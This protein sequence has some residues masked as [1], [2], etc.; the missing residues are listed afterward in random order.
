MWTGQQENGQSIN[1]QA[2]PDHTSEQVSPEPRGRLEQLARQLA[3]NSSVDKNP[4]Q[5]SILFRHLQSWEKT[6]HK[7]YEYF[8]AG[9]SKDLAFSRAAEW[10]LDNF[11]VVEQMLHQIK[12]DLPES[13]YSQLPKLDKTA[14]RGFPRIFELA[15]EWVGYSQGQLELTQ[16]VVFVQDYQQIAPLMIGE[17]W[18]LPT[19]LRIGVLERLTA[20][21]A[22]ITGIT[23]PESLN[24]LPSLPAPPA[25]ANE[26]IVVNCFLSLRLLSAIDWKAFF[27]QTSRVEQILRN[28]PAEIYAGMDFDTRNSYRSVIEELARHSNL[29]EEAT[30][31]AAI[32]L[33]RNP[34][35]AFQFRSV[36]RQTHVGFYLVDEGRSALEKRLNYQPGL[37]VRLRGWFLARPTATYL[38]GINLISLL[39][40]IGLLV[41]THLEGGTLAQLILAGVLGMGLALEAAITLVHWGI[42]HEI[43]PHSLPRM[44]FSQGDTPGIPAG[45]RTMVV[46]PTLLANADELNS[47]LQELEIYYLSNLDPQLSFALLTDFI[48]APTQNM[49][50]DEQL[51]SLAKTGVEK[52]NL[53]YNPAAPFYLFH[54]QREWNPSEGVWM[55]WE[56]KRGKLAEFNQLLLNTEPATSTGYVTQVGDL[57]ILPDIKYVITLDAD[58]SLP[59][60]SA[61][62]LVATLA[63][64]LNQ[65]EFAEDGRSVVAGYTVLQPRVAIKPTSANRSLFS[66]IFAG[67]AGFDLYTLAVSDVYQDLFGEGSYVGKGIYDVSA[68]ERSLV[69]QVRENTLLSHDLFEGIY[70]RAAL[71]TDITLYEEYPTRYLIYTRRLRRWIRGDWQLL[72]WLLPI[73]RTKTGFAPNRLSLISRWKV[74]DNLRRSLLPPTMLAL[75][76]AGWLVLPGSPLVWTLF[77]LLPSALPILA[78]ALQHI[79]QNIGHSSLTELVETVKLPLLRWGLAVLFLPYEAL[80]ILGAIRTTLARLLIS[81]EKLLQWTTAAHTAQSLGVNARF[82]T[83]IEMAVSLAFT[84]LLGSAVAIFN[85]AALIVAA[86]LLIAWLIAPQVAYWISQPITHTAA[87]L[88][89][90]QR[91]EIQRL[92]RRTWAF[93][94][95]F[96]GPQDHWLPPDHFQEAPRGNVAHYTTPTNIGLF[97]LSTL[98]A[99]DLGYVD[100]PELA[101]R[102]QSTFETMD[103]LEHYRGHLL[104][105]YDTQTL[106]SLPPRYISTVDS[107]NL[108]ACLIVLKQ[109]LLVLAD[110]PILG[111]QQW[112]GLLVILDILKNI[113]QQLEQ[114]LEKD[115]PKSAIKPFEVELDS[116]CERVTG[117]QKKPATWMMTSDV[118]LRRRMGSGFPPAHGID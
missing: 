68:F 52:L 32:E 9:L 92:A 111:E 105:W 115:C 69:G 29:S 18:A 13:Y 22:A 5:K 102:L 25:L 86:P 36:I 35:G 26:S 30:A 17:L 10:M 75:F 28:D 79:R 117:I 1:M 33:C 76:A 81:H 8:R 114:E 11:Y 85:Q 20:A 112:Q 34:P 64:P 83:W 100:L 49:P 96:V 77:I 48:D 37:G 113:L 42:T 118:A 6:L 51:L 82:E 87:P 63:H 21:V 55:G 4:K 14:L 39:I 107:G 47:L 53:K 43:A 41:Y 99:H 91:K 97:L 71:V 12:E 90:P 27:E 103:K 50:Q 70:G 54:R 44:D 84:I 40:V 60:G 73:A 80:L 31:Q 2:A 88:S 19:M 94:E 7:A 16:T 110:A 67:N 74:F 46:V 23:T 108:A 45:Y 89:E 95:Q 3:Q 24:A 93:F 66:Q 106:A 116:I 15:W 58:T 38:G 59:Y 56:R 98:S 65:A 109:G 101:V 72:P 57:S 61:S 62:R 78:Q 104:N